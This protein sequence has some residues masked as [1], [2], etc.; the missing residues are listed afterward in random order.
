MQIWDRK[1]IQTIKDDITECHRY[2]NDGRFHRI[3][4]EIEDSLD[5][6]DSYLARAGVYSLKELLQKE[7]EDLLSYG[8]HAWESLQER[9]ERTKDTELATKELLKPNLRVV[10]KKI[11]QGDMSNESSDQ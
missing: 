11:Q 3:L 10:N 2:S 8:V 7:E 6:L 1:Y 5:A 9:V 4:L